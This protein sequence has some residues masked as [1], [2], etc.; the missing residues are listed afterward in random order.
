MADGYIM[1]RGPIRDLV[2]FRYSLRFLL[3]LVLVLGVGFGLA[4]RRADRNRAQR[5]TVERIWRLGG[6]VGY[7]SSD[8]AV[9][10][11]SKPDWEAVTQRS[12]LYDVFVTHTPTSVYFEDRLVHASKLNDENVDELIEAL[13]RLPTVRDV[14]LDSTKLADA[15]K[16]KLQAAL[17][18]RRIVDYPVR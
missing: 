9:L 8:Q 11:F 5:Q 7:E 10:P 2:R 1:P 13:Q 17:P 15:G 16:A 14:F 6:Y 12:W 3:I 4:A 18:D